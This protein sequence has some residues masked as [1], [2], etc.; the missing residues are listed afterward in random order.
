MKLRLD[1]LPQNLKNGLTPIYIVSGD[2]PLL[3][4]E[5]SDLIK[6]NAKEAGFSELERHYIDNQF[7]W[8]TLYQSTQSLSL[9]GDKKLIELRLPNGKPN[10]AGKSFLKDF[11]QKIDNDNLI[12][13][14]TDKLDSASQRAAWFKALEKAGTWVQIWPIEADKLP[15]CIHQRMRQAGLK[16]NNAAVQVIAEKVE[17]NLLAASQE[18]EKLRLVHGEGAIDEEKVLSSITDSAR[19]DIFQLLETAQ[20]GNAAKA[21]KILHGLKQ[22]GLEATPILWAITRELRTLAAM[23]SK[24]ENGSSVKQI[25]QEYRIWEKRKPAIQASLKRLHHKQVLQL[26]QKAQ[27]ADLALK[28]LEKN[29][30]W[31]VFSEIILSISG[32]DF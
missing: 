25:L 19:Y 24:L 15:Q 28:G 12:L 4:Q 10:D 26:I 6:K 2:V 17:G 16:P 22:E 18:I 5:C 9:F 11:A 3:V 31:L 23:T 8:N 13:L 14:I 29:D 20:L 1:Q 32:R 30:P 27:R 21:I 7:N